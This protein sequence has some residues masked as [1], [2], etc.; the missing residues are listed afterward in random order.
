MSTDAW[1]GADAIESS[2]PFVTGKS[3]AYDAGD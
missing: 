3:S 2:H 1:N